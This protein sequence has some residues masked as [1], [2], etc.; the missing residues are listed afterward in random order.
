VSLESSKLMS[1]SDTMMML[2]A[3]PAGAIQPVHDVR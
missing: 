1:R 2:I 3:A